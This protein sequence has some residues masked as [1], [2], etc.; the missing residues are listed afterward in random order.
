MATAAERFA[1]LST[2]SKLLLILTAALLPIGFGLVW[3]AYDGI[4]EANL[5]LKGQSEEQARV[6]ARSIESLIAR[7][8][9]AVRIAANGRLEGPGA[10]DEVRRSLSIAPAVAQRFELE[11][12]DG[13]PICAV[14]TL[15]PTGELPLVAPGGIAVRID[16][17]SNELPM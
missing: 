16:S 17:A 8:A 5:A 4:R 12:P 2:P 1:R 13:A 6:A 14:G 15:P 9:L 11:T 10:C 7:N 3:V